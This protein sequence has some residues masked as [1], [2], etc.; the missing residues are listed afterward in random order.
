MGHTSTPT[1]MKLYST[2]QVAEMYE[3][4]P[5]TVARWIRLGLMRAVKVGRIWRIPEEALHDRMESE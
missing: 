3:V 2:R 1:K 4:S 5:R